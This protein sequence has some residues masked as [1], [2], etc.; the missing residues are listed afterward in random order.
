M[1]FLITLISALK[2][3]REKNNNCKKAETKSFTSKIQYLILKAPSNNVKLK[4]DKILT[5]RI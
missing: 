1:P 5:T 4:I 3:L 2:R